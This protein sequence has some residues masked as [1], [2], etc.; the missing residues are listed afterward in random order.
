MNCFTGDPFPCCAAETEQ[1]KASVGGAE[2]G[3]DGHK[4][5]KEKRWQTE[6]WRVTPPEGAA[7][8]V[9]RYFGFKSSDVHQTTA[10]LKRAVCS[11]PSAE[12]R[13]R[14]SEDS[15]GGRIITF[16]FLFLKF[17]KRFYTS[18]QLST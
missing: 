4:V 3:G 17:N 9:G 2:R 5:R 1:H 16:T 10:E 11:T 7:S 6:R 15:S 18:L 13:F 8:V 12:I 14:P